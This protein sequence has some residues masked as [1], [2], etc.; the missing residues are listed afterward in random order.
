MRFDMLDEYSTLVPFRAGL[1]KQSG[2]VQDRATAT[3]EVKPGA[4]VR[5]IK[6]MRGL[7]ESTKAPSQIRDA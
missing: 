2:V 6:R 3:K 7:L 5:C 4:V 1:F